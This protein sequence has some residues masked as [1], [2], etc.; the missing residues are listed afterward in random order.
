MQKHSYR[1]R[2]DEDSLGTRPQEGSSSSQEYPP[3]TPQPESNGQPSAFGD[4]K[5][6][7]LYGGVGPDREGAMTSPY[8]GQHP[9]RTFDE[10]RAENRKRQQFEAKEQRQQDQ[11]GKSF[12]EGEGPWGRDQKQGASPSKDRPR[13]RRNKYG[14]IIVDDDDE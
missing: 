4:H 13:E 12:G 5:T 10:I 6:S 7:D 9:G 3:N 8:S 11:R 14:D 1:S 2:A